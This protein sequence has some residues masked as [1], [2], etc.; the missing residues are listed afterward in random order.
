MRYLYIASLD[1]VAGGKV[2]KAAKEYMTSKLE[3]RSATY[4]IYEKAL[5]ARILQAQGKRTQAEIL[6]RSIKEYTVVTPE[7]GRYFDTPKAGYAWNGYRIPTQVAAMEAIQHVEKDEKMLEEMKRWLL[8]QS[9]CSAGIHHWLRRMRCMP[10][11]QMA[12]HR[13]SPDRCR[14]WQAMLHWKLRKTDWAVSVIH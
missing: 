6:V 9:R 10:C 14:R 3:N 7:M 2:N 4:S 12:W 1:A 8:K 11:C 13:R 5:I